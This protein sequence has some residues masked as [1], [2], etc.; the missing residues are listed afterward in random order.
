MRSMFGK[1]T[2]YSDFSGCIHLF[3]NRTF[4]KLILE[5]KFESSEQPSHTLNSRYRTDTSKASLRQME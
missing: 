5:K 4:D 3:S 1:N 2:L